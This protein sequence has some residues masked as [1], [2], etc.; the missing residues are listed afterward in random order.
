MKTEI[1][2]LREE[3]AKLRE[4]IAVLETRHRPAGPEL[5]QNYMPWPLQPVFPPQYP[6][7]N[8]EIMC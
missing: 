8:G 3:I 7:R 6:Y 1:E 4:R 2:T 5:G